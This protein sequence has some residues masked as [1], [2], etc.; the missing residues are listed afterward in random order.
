MNAILWA[1]LTACIWGIVPVLEKVGLTK[2]DPFTGLFFRCLGVIIGIL[3]LGTVIVKPAQIKAVDT[4]TI[5]LL[6]MSG[7]L[8]SFVAQIAFYHGLKIGG[9]TKVVPVSATY[10]LIAFVLGVFVLG[11]SL[12]LIKALGM[13]LV[14]AG[15]WMLKLK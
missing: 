14:I 15:V 7:F 3:L 5:I 11:E 12:T 1:V 4:K 6:M 13:M 10:P 8:A 9:V 2:V